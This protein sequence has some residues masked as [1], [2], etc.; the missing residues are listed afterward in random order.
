MRWMFSI[1]IESG[2]T[3]YKI[4]F[5]HKQ[6]YFISNDETMC[7][8]VFIRSLHVE[9]NTLIQYKTI[10]TTYL[11]EEDNWNQ[12]KLGCK[13]TI[14]TGNNHIYDSNVFCSVTHEMSRIIK[15]IM[16]KIKEQNKITI[17]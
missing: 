5:F 11:L 7:M 8:Y 2:T 6:F 1:Y 10:N 13:Y 17:Q 15:N 12:H 9:D 3:S 16:F 14:Q 4:L